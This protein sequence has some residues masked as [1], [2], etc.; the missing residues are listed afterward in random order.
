MRSR[1]PVLAGA[2]LVVV[3]LA[4]AGPAARSGLAQEVLVG[5][6]DIARCDT[7]G[8]E[9]TAALLDGIQGTV[10]TV[11]DHAFT[12]GTEAE[13][14][15][16]YEPTWGR[17]KARTRPSPGNHE[18]DVYPD[19]AA[20]FNYFGAAA[21]EPGKGYYSYDLGAWHVIALNSNCKQ[22]GGCAAGS[23]QESWLRADLAAHPNVC[24]VAYFHATRFSSGV[25]GGSLSVRPFWNALYDYGADVV[26]SS[27]DHDYERFA[28]QD[29]YGVL[30]PTRGLRQFVVGTGGWKLTPFDQIQ[31]NSEVRNAD[32]WGV[33]KLTLRPTSYDWEFV[34]VAGQTFTDSGTARCSGAPDTEAPTVTGVSPA[35]GATEVDVRTSV[36]A[37]FSEKMDA[38]TLTTST[39]TLLEQGS[40]TP[41]DA[42]VTYGAATGKATLDPAADL[43]PGATYTATV[44]GGSGG[45]SDPAGNPLAADKT[46]SFTTTPAPAGDS[47]P[48]G[49]TITTPS[50]GA[51][52]TLNQTVNAD[53]ACEDEAG[54]SGLA[55]CDGT[56][57][58][59]API[60]TGSVGSKTFTVTAADNA[61]N[62]ASITRAYTVTEAPSPD[63][64]QTGT[65][66]NDVISG[67]EGN[68]VICGLG[69]R[70]TLKGL[71]GDDVLRGGDGNDTLMGGP[72]DDTL[73]GGSGMNTVSFYGS[74]TAVTASLA[75]GTATGEGSDTLLQIRNLIGSTTSDTLTGSG[76]ANMLRGGAG[77]DTVRGGTGNDSVVGGG[78]PDRLFGEDGDDAVDSRDGVNGNDTLDGGPGTDTKV[79]D[80]SE[81]SIT[82]FP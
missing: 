53:Y 20:Y 81:A 16:C 57:A 35:D 13:F 44:K 9:A 68:D 1:V 41:V 75:T 5:A 30:D 6:G 61:G 46:W 22:V 17:F 56:V 55:S 27:M 66:G 45:A 52:Y 12:S 38:A 33:L 63:C 4:L 79:T 25:S 48:P 43:D 65:A 74:P 19:A 62:T 76:A 10:F 39:F 51:V 77:R 32:T 54:G 28:P 18:Y 34:P 72:G 59:G 69:G 71:G 2:A 70:D 47:T 24:T 73:E 15:N 3:L 80:A 78:G 37:I 64:T 29:P 58:S 82:G 42:T 14:A 21:G 7:S 31:P 50:D 36:E 60:D 26:L 40:S 8:D 49:I 11:G 23:P 67:T